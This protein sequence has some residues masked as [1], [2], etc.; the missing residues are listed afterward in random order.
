[1]DQSSC[2][3]FG[4]L[5][6]HMNACILYLIIQLN[7]FYYVYLNGSICLIFIIQFSNDVFFIK[8]YSTNLILNELLNIKMDEKTFNLIISNN[9]GR[10]I[11]KR[12]NNVTPLSII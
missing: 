9:L 7:K 12:K 1:M 8:L 2:V 3:R 5:V 11:V 4:L 6:V 10:K